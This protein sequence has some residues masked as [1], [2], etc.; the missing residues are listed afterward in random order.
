MT[1]QR[2]RRMSVEDSL[3]RI[4]QERQEELASLRETRSQTLDFLGDELSRAQSNVSS[5]SVCMGID[6]TYSSIVEQ[7]GRRI[8]E[9]VI[10]E[11]STGWVYALFPALLYWRTRGV[12]LSVVLKKGGEDTVHGAYRRRLL[13]ALGA[14][15]MEVDAIPVRAFLFD[16][17]SRE[18]ATGVM[19]LQGKAK[20]GEAT[21][22]SSP[23][24]SSA[25]AAIRKEL[26][27]F[28]PAAHQVAPTG[29]PRLVAGRHEDLISALRKVRQYARS[30]VRLTLDTVPINSLVSLTHYVRDYKYR[31]VH[32]LV[33]LYSENSLDCFEPAVVDFGEGHRSLLTPPVVEASNGSYVLIEG[34]SRAVYCRDNKIERIVCIVVKNIQDPLPSKQ[35]IDIGLVEIT[36]KTLEPDFRYGGLD[37]KHFR[38][39]E[40]CVHSPHNFR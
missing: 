40:F 17:N 1:S 6:E 12:R 11:E 31:Q 36:K 4:A 35:Y 39:I 23:L 28:F 3:K 8:Q 22:Y 30:E 37:L 5:S 18:K 26:C 19:G 25:V 9:V 14:E 16:G 10:A 34:S 33:R 21:R 32:Y 20:R 15:V 13:R 24:D 38:K 7:L 2:S 29:R 27:S